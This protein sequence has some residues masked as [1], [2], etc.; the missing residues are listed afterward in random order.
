MRIY[1]LDN[2]VRVENPSTTA[3]AAPDV[4]VLY[5]L[6]NNTPFRRIG[7]KFGFSSTNLGEN[8]TQT[9]GV[10]T[11]VLPGVGFDFFTKIYVSIGFA[12]KSQS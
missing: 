1:T 4:L 3:G 9:L 11:G 5:N 6:Q 7:A 12:R 8:F 2:V 10:E